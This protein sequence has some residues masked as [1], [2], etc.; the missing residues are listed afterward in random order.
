MKAENLPIRAECLRVRDRGHLEAI[1]YV[2]IPLRTI[3]T[4]LYKNDEILPSP[5][6]FKLM[7]VPSD[8]LHNKPE[9]H[10]NVIIQPE[11]ECLSATHLRGK[12]DEDDVDDA[13]FAEP[14]IDHFELKMTD[15]EEPEEAN[16]NLPTPRIEVQQQSVAQRPPSAKETVVAKDPQV[17]KLEAPKPVEKPIM[18][19]DTEVIPLTTEPAVDPETYKRKLEEWKNEEKENFLANLKKVENTFLES[20][21][22]EW[23]RKKHEEENKLQWTIEECERLSKK[24]EEGYAQMKDFQRTETDMQSRNAAADHAALQ[25]ELAMERKRNITL[26]MELREE[27]QENK[28]L[29]DRIRQLEKQNTAMDCEMAEQIVSNLLSLTDLESLNNEPPTENPRGFHGK[30][31]ALQGLLQTKVVTIDQG[32]K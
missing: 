23:Q 25:E 27:R 11:Q 18:K 17:Q 5:R 30:A 12:F 24:L 21:F 7:G 22:E 10:L 9:L 29:R 1:G 31:K 16:Q 14:P 15:E 28:S 20:M 2:L 4:C 26:E 8:V 3:P 13:S 6:W 32:G 19:R